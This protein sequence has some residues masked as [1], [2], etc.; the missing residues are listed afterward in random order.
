MTPYRQYI[1]SNSQHFR[2]IF[3]G[4]NVSAMSDAVEF[5]PP[6][7]PLTKEEK[8]LQYGHVLHKRYKV[9]VWNNQMARIWEDENGWDMTKLRPVSDDQHL[10]NHIGVQE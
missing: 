3:H 6:V 9:R 8:L 4:E 2:S 10:P 1:E 7:V 5:D